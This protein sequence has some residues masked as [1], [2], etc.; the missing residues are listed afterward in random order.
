MA[1]FILKFG[2]DQYMIWSTVV[3]APVT[4]M[5]SLEELLEE[6]GTDGIQARLER[7]DQ[8]GCSSLRHSLDRILI[9]NRA[10]DGETELTKAE[11]IEKYTEV[12]NADPS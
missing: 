12:P 2:P 1:Q 3:D 8:N 9:C 4:M 10:G 5:M 7:C 6:Q 11:I